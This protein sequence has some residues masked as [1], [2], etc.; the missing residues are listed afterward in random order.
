MQAIEDDTPII[1]NGREHIGIRNTIKRLKILYGEQA[2]IK[3]CNMA[4][5]YGAVVEIMLP[6][7][8]E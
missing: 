4:E 1:Y 8:H 2:S 3:L 6:I 5:N 7:K